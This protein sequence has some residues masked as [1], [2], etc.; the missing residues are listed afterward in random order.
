MS[1][2]YS[3]GHLTYYCAYL[4]AHY[5][6]EFYAAIISTETDT[7]QQAIYMSDARA[8]GIDILPPS[9]N[10][11]D[12]GFKTTDNGNIYY[13]LSGIKGI[14]SSVYNG[15]IGLRPYKSLADF[16]IRSYLNIP[17]INKKTYD[18]LIMSGCLDMFGY[19][20]SVLLSSYEKFLLDFDN[21]DI[22]KLN[23]SFD[24]N[25]K[26]FVSSRIREFL[27]LES[28]YFKNDS[29]EEFS[30]LQILDFESSLLGIYLTANPFDIV[31]N[32]VEVKYYLAESAISAVS[33]TGVFV[34]NLL[35]KIDSI[36]EIKTK[37]G[38][39]MAFAECTD[40]DGFRFSVTFFPNIYAE[41][42]DDISSNIYAILLVSGKESYKK[43]GSV[44]FV[45]N[46]LQNLTKEMTAAS[47]TESKRNAIKYANIRF[48]SILPQVTYRNILSK[49]E[50]LCAGTSMAT[51]SSR[52]YLDFL[53]RT[54]TEVSESQSMLMRIGPFYKDE[55]TIDDVRL[56]NSFKGA[57]VG[58]K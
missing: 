33:N 8:K 57:I 24:D 43:D 31:K 27:S 12:I 5:P 26:E 6:V 30:V 36:R 51:A 1:H 58:T 45:V 10:E 55:I 50:S 34:G 23:K 11:S 3:Y 49:V 7:E 42:K 47:Q 25:D 28:E 38:D 56:F 35:V 2:A 15:L 20:R 39:T 29:M 52:I 21:G 41:V 37:R 4:K 48:N 40:H 9:V 17:R 22:K 44:D 53:I 32:S 18:A 13:G 54:N 46:R 14:G 19:K 16:F